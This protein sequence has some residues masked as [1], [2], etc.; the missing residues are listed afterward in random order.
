MSSDYEEPDDD[1]FGQLDANALDQLET[2]AY[3]KHSAASQAPAPT[4]SKST[5]HQ[6]ARPKNAVAGPSRLGMGRKADPRP[7]NV[8]PGQT[9]SGFGW[10]FG[11]KRDA[12][13]ERH[14]GN[15]EKRSMYWGGNAH[16]QGYPGAVMTDTGG[17]AVN[18]DLDPEGEVVDSLAAT[19]M[20]LPRS[21]Q[22]AA[23]ARR[24]AIFSA[25]QVPSGPPINR[26]TP[27]RQPAPVQL[28]ATSR[29]PARNLSRSVSAG[30][31]PLPQHGGQ[32]GRFSP[33]LPA[34]AS[35]TE[36]PPASQGSIARRT[37][38]ELEE[39]RKRREA[40]E[41]E[42]Q[43]LRK[44]VQDVS[45]RTPP[46]EI[47]DEG[48]LV[49]R[50]K[51]M[52]QE[53]WVARGEAEAL[54]RNQRRDKQTQEEG[55]NRYRAKLAE[56]EAAL[57]QKEIEANRRIE[58]VKTQAVFQN[59]A[60]LS[61]TTKARISNAM[62]GSQTPA[63][64]L[65]SSPRKN[66]GSQW[67]D[68][69][70]KAK[71]KMRAPPPPPPAFGK[72]SNAFVETPTITG[73]VKRQ[74]TE[75]LSPS[76]IKAITKASEPPSGVD[77]DEPMQEAVP[78]VG[79]DGDVFDALP[80]EASMQIEDDE[81]AMDVRSL[82][83]YHLFHH[84]SLSA[85]Q[86]ALDPESITQPT[87]YR[88]F[89]HVPDTGQVRAAHSQACGDILRMCGDTD[90]SVEMMY[91]HLAGSLVKLV[92]VHMGLLWIPASCSFAALETLANVLSLLARTA[93]LFPSFVPILCNIADGH[94]TALVSDLVNKI[95]ATPDG[96]TTFQQ[97]LLEQA[98]EAKMDV[99][100]YDNAN[101][102]KSW[103]QDLA[104]FIADLATALSWYSDG[105]P[106]W[107]GSQ[108]VDILLCLTC[109]HLDP[110]IV[111]KGVEAI[112]GISLNRDNFRSALQTSAIH[113]LKLGDQP[114]L[115]RISRLL[116]VPPSGW[117]DNET[118]ELTML[119]IRATQ[120]LSI[121]DQDAVLLIADKSIIPL[122]LVTLI[123][124]ESKPVWGIEMDH[125]DPSKSLKM[126]QALLTLLHHLVYPIAL[127]I[128][129]RLSTSSSQRQRLPPAYTS[130]N[131]EPEPD[132]DD[133]PIGINLMDRIS[134][135]NQPRE[136]AG[137]PHL[138]VSALGRL[139]YADPVV[140]DDILKAGEK[141]GDWDLRIIQY[142][143]QDI[144][145]SVVEGPEGDAV[146]ELYAG[147]EDA[148]DGSATGTGMADMGMDE[149]DEVD[150]DVYAEVAG[151]E[152]DDVDMD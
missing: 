82:L 34:V 9:G 106:P 117:N 38:L 58:S 129:P 139:S 133:I 4:A 131:D 138:F 1:L 49:Q 91:Q 6:L 142:M 118:H 62:A 72:L 50:L 77:I 23:Q 114:L 136:F 134:R 122:A 87:I 7:L 22:A 33:N 43:A 147:E 135:P 61:S 125:R 57:H 2:V 119:L 105:S 144:L 137:I 59:H 73:R 68:M 32:N 24:Q 107:Q 102:E 71:G 151:G 66:G 95:Y 3:A 51:T 45:R 100:R 148:E 108:L 31:H 130:A 79:N 37:A 123:E 90:L 53:L 78:E 29:F 93:T 48:D 146:Y 11:G 10:E 84:N 14:I 89:N 83:L 75:G 149:G 104:W 41:A 85:L 52:E 60:V 74:R 19:N 109:P 152:H 120:Q 141:N 67:E 25:S 81:E 13:L 88:I 20:V 128:A 121:A 65:Q 98:T 113:A 150:E 132:T 70:A 127:N 40:V 110:K 16:N 56:M 103:S 5:H 28:Q 35:Q 64:G 46:V 140:D 18:T 54:R 101:L 111:K 94:I 116:M 115:E 27:I 86:T 21:T 36:T 12:D 76:P 30:S 26:P 69:S 44:Q 96:I 145:E 55:E 126:L 112:W 42:L 143:A 8:R 17:Y 39:E 15:V 99:D 80:G 124:R 97:K 47:V 92:E 63:R